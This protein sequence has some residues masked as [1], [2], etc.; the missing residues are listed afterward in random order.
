[1]R[2]VEAWSPRLALSSS[3]STN[4]ESQAVARGSPGQCCLHR[5]LVDWILL[6]F[7]SGTPGGTCARP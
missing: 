5:K 3:W 6:E 1:M 2:E 4:L 7:A